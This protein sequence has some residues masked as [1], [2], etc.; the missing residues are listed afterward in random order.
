MD[1]PVTVFRHAFGVG[2]VVGDGLACGR[3]ALGHALLPPSVSVGRSVGHMYPFIPAGML[4]LLG[5]RLG[6]LCRIAD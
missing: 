6:R 3:H 1:T 4:I 2:G 5:G